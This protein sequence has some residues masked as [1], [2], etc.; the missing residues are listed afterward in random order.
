[1]A[2]RELLFLLLALEVVVFVFAYGVVLARG[3]MRTTMT[4]RNIAALPQRNVVR[5]LAYS[6]IAQ[7]GYRLMGVARSRHRSGPAGLVYYAIA[8][9][10]MN[11]AAVAVVL[12]LKRQRNSVDLRASEVSVT[13]TPGGRPPPPTLQGP[14]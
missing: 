4:L 13:S 3:G 11:L 7:S 10:A 1:M 2:A 6:S 8:Y 14:L 9:A 12:A 5:L